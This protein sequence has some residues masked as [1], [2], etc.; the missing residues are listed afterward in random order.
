VVVLLDN[1]LLGVRHQSISA[2]RDDYGDRRVLGWGPADGGTM[3][4]RRNE[5]SDGLWAL[6]VD[7][8]LWPVR[9][10]DL[11]ISTDGATW[12]VDTSDLVQNSY[13]DYVNYIRLTARLRSKGGTEP[14]DAW[15]VARYTPGLE[16][17]PVEPSG[18]PTLNDE[19]IWTGQGPPPTDGWPG[20]QPGDEYVDRVTGI[21]YHWEG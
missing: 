19:G 9:Q 18:E 7:P 5:Q 6:A 10:N 15:F 12:L 8:S 21:V 2:A 20:V 14:G 11:V 13:D 1:C 17:F 16:D 3:P 4:G